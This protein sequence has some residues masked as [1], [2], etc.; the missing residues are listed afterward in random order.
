MTRPRATPGAASSTPATRREPALRAQ[1]YRLDPDMVAPWDGSRLYGRPEKG[2]KTQRSIGSRRYTSRRLG[3]VKNIRAARLD[4]ASPLPHTGDHRRA[5][6]TS[7]VT[8]VPPE[9]RLSAI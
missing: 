8:R 6:P 1:R 5:W 4:G 2:V 3:G 9:G 7:C